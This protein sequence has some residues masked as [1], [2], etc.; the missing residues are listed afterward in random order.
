M[1]GFEDKSR[2]TLPDDEAGK[3]DSTI[4][5]DK[6]SMNNISWKEKNIYKRTEMKTS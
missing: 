1:A 5:Y 6:S 2:Y 3:Q 4:Y